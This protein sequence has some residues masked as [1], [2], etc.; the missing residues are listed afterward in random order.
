LS[1]ENLKAVDIGRELEVTDSVDPILVWCD[2][3]Q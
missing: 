1:Q 3:V 2:S